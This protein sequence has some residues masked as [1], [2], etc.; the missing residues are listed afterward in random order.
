MTEDTRAPVASTSEISETIKLP[1]SIEPINEVV[2]MSPKETQT[3]SP[4]PVT[5]VS[6]AI[7]QA[8]Q[9]RKERL[10]KRA[11]ELGED[12]DVFMTITE[13]DRLDSTAF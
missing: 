12:L 7:L 2:N 4:K 3:N 1:E 9:Q 5:E 8:R 6:S 10:R 11:V 13:K